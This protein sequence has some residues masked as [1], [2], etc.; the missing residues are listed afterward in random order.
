M[1]CIRS[2]SISPK[3]FSI[4]AAEVICEPEEVFQIFVEI[5]DDLTMNTGTYLALKAR[6]S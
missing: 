1:K 5:G 6:S 3:K 4:I 2:R